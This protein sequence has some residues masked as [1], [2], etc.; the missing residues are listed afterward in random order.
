MVC[1]LC[2]FNYM[3]ISDTRQRVMPSPYD[4]SNGQ[5]L[6]YHEAVV[7]TNPSNPQLKGEVG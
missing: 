4:R 6:D 7:L 1:V 5:I 3:A 2:R